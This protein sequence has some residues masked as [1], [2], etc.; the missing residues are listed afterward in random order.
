MHPTA[1]NPQTFEG[2][3]KGINPLLSRRRA[4]GLLRFRPLCL[5]A[6]LRWRKL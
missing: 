6:G 5:Q 2:F 1:L 4:A 3:G